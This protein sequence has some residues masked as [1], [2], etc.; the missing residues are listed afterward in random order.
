[1]LKFVGNKMFYIHFR[2]KLHVM[3]NRYC[4]IDRAFFNKSELNELISNFQ[5]DFQLRIIPYYNID[6]I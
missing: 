6:F 5:F 2:N 1:M 4:S 3:F